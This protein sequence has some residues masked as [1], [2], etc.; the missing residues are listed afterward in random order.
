MR[1]LALHAN[2]ISFTAKSKAIKDAEDISPHAEQVQECLVVFSSVEQRDERDPA[3]VARRYVHEVADIASQVSAKK[4]VLYPYVHLSSTPSSPKTALQVLTAA[5]KE[6]KGMGYTVI[7]APFGWYKEFTISCKGHPLAELSRE[8]SAEAEEATALAAEKKLE[9][10]WFVLDTAGKL[11]EV[12]MQD[13][14][15]TG[16]SFAQH[17]NLELFAKYEM[18]KA[19]VAK[20]EPPHVSLMKKLELVGYEPG[21]D[22]GHFRYY[23]KGR[24]IK[25]LLETYITDMTVAYG[26]LEV[27]TPI[28][29]DM[30]HPSLAKYLAK[31]PARQYVIESDKRN[32]FLRFSA[33]FGQFLI[34]HDAQVSYKNLPLR[35]YELT[36]YSFRREQSG[37]LSGLRRLR[38]FTMPDV[39]A[40]CGSLPQAMEEYRRR[41]Q[42]CMD[43]ITGI[44]L[45]LDELEL[46]LRV[47]SDF[48]KEHKD[49]IKEIVR[50]FGKPALIE[51]WEQRAFYFILKY[52]FNFVDT[53]QKA[54]AL[55]TDQ[56]DVENGERYGLTFAD[57][58]NTKKIIP[59][60]LHCSPSGAI[61]RVLYALLE[62]AYREQQAGKKPS[63][64][65]WLAPTQVR[66]IPV[67]NEKHLK[68][69]EAV[70]RQLLSQEVR[71]DVDDNEDT[72]GKRI[73]RAEEEW[74]PYIVVVGDKEMQGK[75]LMTRLRESGLQQEY[76]QE[77]LVQE[78]RTKTAGK[79]WKPLALPMLLS[80]RA[81]FS[82]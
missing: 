45:P 68:L 46:A 64:P 39:H 1:I 70:C 81:L 27:E 14:A 8:F 60:I 35:L 28:M 50:I 20:Q 11:H 25:K 36:R 18:A 9:S 38:A 80:Q 10:S 33:C 23:P 19:R 40:L 79:P 52:E 55:C 54:A 13:N 41:L 17:P 71:A 12:E 37:E 16:F 82:S 24:L 63:L 49:F 57:K 58:D 43:V 73:K 30:Q 44:G 59:Y 51:M 61:E 5:E 72:L 32:F 75:M 67:S 2:Q 69:A 6:L 29:Y 42:L 21:S 7:R 62:K 77:Q 76:T 65:L 48:Y 78:I 26:G 66:I 74:V 15:I 56:I 53:L 47:T 4:I 34:A 3:A 31:F 22:S